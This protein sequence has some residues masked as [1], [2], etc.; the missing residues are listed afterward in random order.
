MV[1]AGGVKVDPASTNAV[2]PA[3]CLDIFRQKAGFRSIITHQLAQ[4]IQRHWY[5]VSK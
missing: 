3:E 1:S 2:L 5:V 4:D